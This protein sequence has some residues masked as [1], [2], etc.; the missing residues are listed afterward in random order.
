[1][2]RFFCLVSK[3]EKKEIDVGFSNDSLM[4]AVYVLFVYL[5]ECMQKLQCQIAK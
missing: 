5:F 2:K 4:L 1:M 3:F